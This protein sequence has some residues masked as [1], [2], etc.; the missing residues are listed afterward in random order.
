MPV[1][2]EKSEPEIVYV[3]KDLREQEGYV[4]KEV[5]DIEVQTSFDES[6]NVDYLNGSMQM[7]KSFSNMSLIE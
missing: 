7:S 3:Y 2:V 1:K 5:N 4:E 6:I